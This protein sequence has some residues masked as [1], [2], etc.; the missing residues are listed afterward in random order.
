MPQ[1]PGRIVACVSYP[2]ISTAIVHLFNAS[3]HHS[4]KTYI[5]KTI[6]STIMVPFFVCTFINKLRGGRW[7]DESGGCK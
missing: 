3:F 5:E 1:L 4:E 6:V 7:V 2:P